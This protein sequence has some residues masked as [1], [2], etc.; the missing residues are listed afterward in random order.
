MATRAEVM[1]ALGQH[2]AARCHEIQTNVQAELMATT[3]VDT[4]F[5]RGNWQATIDSPA[6]GLVSVIAP[7]MAPPG[8]GSDPSTLRFVTN[9]AAYI[10][11]LNGGSSTQAPSGFVEAAVAKAVRS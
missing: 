6:E 4:G 2:V 5:A 1:A 10:R 9:N 3:P 7:A 8:P 11:R